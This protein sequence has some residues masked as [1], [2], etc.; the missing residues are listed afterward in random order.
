MADILI[1][2]IHFLRQ[3]TQWVDGDETVSLSVANFDFCQYNCKYHHA[4]LDHPG[5]KRCVKEEKKYGYFISHVRAPCLICCSVLPTTG[6]KTGSAYEVDQAYKRAMA[7]FQLTWVGD[8]HNWRKGFPVNNQA[9]PVQ[10]EERCPFEQNVCEP[11]EKVRRCACN[12]EAP[13][14]VTVRVRS[15]F[16]KPP[17]TTT[18]IL[19]QYNVG[20][21]YA[22]YVERY[23]FRVVELLDRPTAAP[24]EA[25]TAAANPTFGPTEG[26]TK[27]P[28]ITVAPTLSPT[29]ETLFVPPAPNVTNATLPPAA[30]ATLAPTALGPQQLE[31]TL[32]CDDSAQSRKR[33][34]PC[35]RGSVFMVENRTVADATLDA[36][37]AGWQALGCENCN[38]TCIHHTP[39]TRPTFI[40]TTKELDSNFFWLEVIRLN[41]P[42]N[43]YTHDLEVMWRPLETETDVTTYIRHGASVY[44]FPRLQGTLFVKGGKVAG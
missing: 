24:T 11:D 20:N 43:R 37:V 38:K 16:A 36:V 23:A 18:P 40:N 22:D 2:H 44:G 29:N 30:N 39:T 12:R 26:P 41:A 27:S 33:A 6:F 15:Q 13:N 25:P 14:C 9:Q 19:V 1:D 31:C 8:T 28:T 3:V 34:V 7:H 35:P 32:S 17:S 5:H 21:K 4:D 10:C 42:S